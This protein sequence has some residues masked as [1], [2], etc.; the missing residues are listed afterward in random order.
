MNNPQ[1]STVYCCGGAFLKREEY[2][3][4]DFGKK[5]GT[6]TLVRQ[7]LYWQIFCQCSLPKGTMARLYTA[8]SSETVKLGLLCPEGENFCLRTRISARTLPCGPLRFFLRERQKLRVP[9]VPQEPFAYLHAL[10]V[11]K[12][13]M[14]QGSA[15]MEL[16][17]KHGE[18]AK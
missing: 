6:V 3:V 12:L 10:P 5:A 2:D 16:A 9:I 17:E 1:A 7:G 13:T 8:D 11:G 14:E 4:M 18:K 15:Y